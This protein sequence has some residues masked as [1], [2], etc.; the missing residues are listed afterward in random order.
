MLPQ[1]LLSLQDQAEGSHA[2]LGGKRQYLASWHIAFPVENASYARE[3]SGTI[4][5]QVMQ[6]G[7]A[8]GIYLITGILQPPLLAFQHNQRLHTEINGERFSGI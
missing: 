7:M 2:G 4:V 5:Q 8:S 1:Q 6:E 3:S